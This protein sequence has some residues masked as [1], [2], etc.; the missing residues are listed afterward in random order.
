MAVSGA[1]QHDRIRKPGALWMPRALLQRK[2]TEY[3]RVLRMLTIGAAALAWVIV[4]VPV[5]VY[6]TLRTGRPV[7]VFESWDD[8]VR[9]WWDG[10]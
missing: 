3:M 4:S 1:R 7:A 5:V 2:S 10:R 9:D 6:L 8:Y